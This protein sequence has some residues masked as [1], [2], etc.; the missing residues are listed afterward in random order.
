MNQHSRRKKLLDCTASSR[1]VVE[2]SDAVFVVILGGQNYR[3][4][5]GGLGFGGERLVGTINQD[6]RYPV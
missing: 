4:M 5:G 2:F 1:L 6:R 3:R